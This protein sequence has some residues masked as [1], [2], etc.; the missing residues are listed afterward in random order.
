MVAAV[1]A[2]TM[3]CLA[4]LWE[5]RADRIAHAKERAELLQ[6]IQA[7]AVAVAEHVRQDAP[8]RLYVAPD[9]DQAYWESKAS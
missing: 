2:L 1:V 9:D 7:P 8:A 3:I 5:R 4:L 6:R